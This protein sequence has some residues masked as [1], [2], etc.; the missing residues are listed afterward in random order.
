MV[1]VFISQP[2]RDKT[3]DE[4]VADRERAI[5]TVKSILGTDIEIIDSYFSNPPAEATVLWCLGES[6]KLLGEAN[7]VYFTP[8]WEKARGCNIE[9]CVAVSYDIPIIYG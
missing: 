7:I 5:E 6:I 2:M 8:G 4:I 3:H 9:H 1:S